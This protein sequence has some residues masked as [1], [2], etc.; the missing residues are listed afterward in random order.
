MQSPSLVTKKQVVLELSSFMPSFTTYGDF[1]PAS[2]MEFPV[3]QTTHF[4]CD[5]VMRIAYW[6]HLCF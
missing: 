4:S 1:C 3:F 6:M 5:P 2:R